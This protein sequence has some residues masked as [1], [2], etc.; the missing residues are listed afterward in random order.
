M[1][2]HQDIDQRSL[3]LSEAIAHRIDENPAI[4]NKVRETCDKWM[5]VH[6]QPSVSEWLKIL[7]RPWTEVR[8]VLLEDSERGRRLRQS[9]P[10]CGILLPRERWQVYKEFQTR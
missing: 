9:S 7:S 5:N 8:A 3:A 2:T 6:P 4:L 10:F 1:K